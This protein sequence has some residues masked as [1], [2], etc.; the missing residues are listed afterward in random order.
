MA[1]FPPTSSRPLHLLWAP[2]DAVCPPSPLAQQGRLED[3]EAKGR[4]PGDGLHGQS[5]TPAEL[6]PYSRNMIT[7]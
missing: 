1:S 5:G 3:V 2:I 7:V 4:R 6:G